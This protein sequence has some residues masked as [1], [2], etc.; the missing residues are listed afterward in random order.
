M[1]AEARDSLGPD[2]QGEGEAWERRCVP[3][4]RAHAPSLLR[5]SSR[6]HRRCSSSKTS[7]DG[8]VLDGTRRQIVQCTL[9]LGERGGQ[10]EPINTVGALLRFAFQINNK[11]FD[12]SE[13][14]VGR[15]PRSCL[16]APVLRAFL[17]PRPAPYSPSPS[18]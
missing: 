1:P 15:A 5:A 17:A 8:L 10:V 7:P 13:T 12:L 14:Q 11:L 6:R 9:G 2:T 4:P 3:G 16:A 18:V